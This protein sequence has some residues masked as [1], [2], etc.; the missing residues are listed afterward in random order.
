MDSIS[1]RCR[2]GFTLVELLVV[3]A[4]IGVLVA[5]LLPAVQAAREAA[6]RSQCQNNLRQLGLAM[7]NF[8]DQRGG[9]PPLVTHTGYAS[10]FVHILPFIEQNPMYEMLNGNNSSKNTALSTVM[11]TNW[12]NLNSTEQNA[13]GSL[14][15][16]LCPSRRSGT[17]ISMNGNNSDGPVSDYAVVHSEIST[18]S[19]P[20]NAWKAHYDACTAAHATN[21]EAAIRVA[22]VEGCNSPAAAQLLAARPRDTFARVTDGLSNTL[23]VGEKHLRVTELGLYGTGNPS[24]NTHMYSSNTGNHDVSVA[25]EIRLPMGKGPNSFT[26]SGDGPSATFGFG[27]WHSGICLFAV[28]DGS[29]KSISNNINQGPGT[30]PPTA[31]YLLGRCNDGLPPPAE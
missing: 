8:H 26:A 22:R 1:R 5:L 24:D 3:I 20:G 31:L 4:I 17:N 13:F 19:A 27:S 11:T 7:Q 10:F 29:V 21:N 2:R 30:N 6:R 9:I 16:Y 28:G 14:Q 12:T 25:R 18:Q 15:A 23:F